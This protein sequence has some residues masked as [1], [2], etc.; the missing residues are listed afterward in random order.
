[1][2]PRDA[3]AV[4]GLGVAAPHGDDP[5]ALFEALM[6]G[7]SAL[8][9]VFEAELPKPAAAATLLL[10]R[11]NQQDAA[12]AYGAVTEEQYPATPPSSTPANDNAATF[13]LLFDR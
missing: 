5:V 7:E 1:M 11:L 10:T 6:R 2:T 3:V 8:R 12:V 9:P 13:H 4:T